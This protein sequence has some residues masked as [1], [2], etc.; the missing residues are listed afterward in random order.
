LVLNTGGFGGSNG[1][2]GGVD[3]LLESS[4]GEGFIAGL[5][6]GGEDGGEGSV[7]VLGNGFALDAGGFKVRG[8]FGHDDLLASC[9]F[10]QDA[11]GWS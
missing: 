4:A 1:V 7:G 6:K 5:V 11:S 3:D 9:C 2:G 8:F 10:S